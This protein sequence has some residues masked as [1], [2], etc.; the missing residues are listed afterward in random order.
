MELKD[1]IVYIIAT[2]KYA[3]L[4]VLFVIDTLGVF[5]PS[6][7]I[8]TLTG[9][10][11]QTGQLSLAP[12]FFS[13]LAG[14]LTGFCISYS[15]GIRIGKPFLVKYG[16]RL[17]ITDEKIN[18]AQGWFSRFGPAFIILAYFTPGLRHITPYLA[19]IAGLAF[20]RVI[21]F[22]AIGASLWI[23]TFVSLGSFFGQRLDWLA[24][25]LDRYQ[26]Q[27]VL[28][29]ALAVLLILGLKR[30]SRK[31]PAQPED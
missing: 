12:L 2:Y 27:A 8:L 16:R 29:A 14:S 23:T 24:L 9:V 30:R 3:G 6:K 19:G 10:L 18:R 1:Q 13:A 11:V 5:L 4:Y 25:L 21:T 28:L 17:K 20:P 31:A 22:A 26:W 7:T 15:I